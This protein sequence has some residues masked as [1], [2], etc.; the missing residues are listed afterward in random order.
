MMQLQRTL[1]LLV[2]SVSVA[3]SGI[4]GC[5]PQTQTNAQTSQTQTD[6]QTPLR[7][8]D[9]VFV[10]TPQEVVDQMLA[11]AKVTKDD[12]LYDVVVMGGFQLQQRKGSAR[13]V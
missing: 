3:S 1:C 13:G 12:V 7:E 6:V 8:P 4:A 2:A 11:L 9:V 10:P 5:V